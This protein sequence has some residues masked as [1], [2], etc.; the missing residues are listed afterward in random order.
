M[1]YNYCFKQLL[2]LWIFSFF[3]LSHSLIIIDEESESANSNETFISLDQFFFQNNSN[4]LLSDSLIFK[5]NVSC[6]KNFIIS[7]DIRIL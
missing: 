6:K 2:L 3:N 7:N 4:P 5:S 1:F